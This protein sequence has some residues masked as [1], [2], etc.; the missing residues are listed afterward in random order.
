MEAVYRWALDIHP[1]KNIVFRTPNGGF[2]E[3]GRR[4]KNAFDLWQLEARHS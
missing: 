3:E 1:I 2:A 4:R